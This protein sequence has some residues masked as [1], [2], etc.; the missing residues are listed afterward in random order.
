MSWSRTERSADCYS[1][2]HDPL[3]RALS[4]TSHLPWYRCIYPESVAFDCILC[5]NRITGPKDF[6]TTWELIAQH[7]QLHVEHLGV[8]KV[9][10]AEA[11]YALRSAPLVMTGPM[12]A[13]GVGEAGGWHQVI[14]DVWGCIP[15]TNLSE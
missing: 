5:R 7:E 6:T 1:V 10:A 2:L 15:D 9:A 11:L 14:L 13:T 12:G 4:N 3:L 8:E